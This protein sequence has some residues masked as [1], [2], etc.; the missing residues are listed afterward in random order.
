MF[1]N[2]IKVAF[3]NILKQRVFSFINIFGLAVA[4]SICMGI[5]MLVADQMMVDR[6]NPLSN[7]IYRINSIPYFKD[8][9][10]QIPGN[11]T[12]T[13]TLPLRDELLNNYTGVE[14]AVRLMRG[15]GNGWLELEPNHDINVPV[16]GYFADP[17]VL[18][19]FNHE[20]Q[21]GDPKTALVE[22]YSVVLTKK[23]A[24]KL[25]KVENPVGES[26]KVGKLGTYKV[27]G[28]IKETEN[29]SHIVVDAFASMSTVKS[30]A[31]AN[32]LG[33]EAESWHAYT[34]GWVYILLEEGK[35]I[36]DIQSSL[37]KISIDHFSELTPPHTTV[38]KYAFQNLLEIVPGRMIN[39]PIGPFMPW[40]II[41]F[42]AGI[43]GI[44]LVTSCF[45]FTN[46]S[47]ARS[48]S[49][50]KEIGVRKVTGAS[51]WQL[52]T[53]FLSESVIIS[54]FALV[55]GIVMIY[56][57][58]PFIVD[59]AFAR[60]LKW[61]LSA[62]YLVYGVFFVFAVFVGLL[63]GLF[64][65]GVLSGFQPIK[66]L[67]DMANTRLMSK[68]GLR[69]A[70]LVVQFSLSM[71]FILTVIVIY[72]QLNLFLHN[73]N[74]FSTSNKLIVHRGNTSVVS[75]K[76][77]LEKQSNIVSVSAASHIPLAGISYGD[78]FK[79]SLDE[80]EWRNASYFS[81]DENYLENMNLTLVAGKFFSAE[82]GASNSNFIILNE[83]AV[84]QHQFGS[85]ADAIGQVLI[86]ERDSAEMQILGVVKDYHFEFLDD[87]LGPLALIYNPEEFSLLQVVYAG[88][89]KSAT[90]TVENVWAGINPGLKVEVRD[91]EAEMGTLYEIVFGTLVKVLGF[92]AFLAIVIS[93][94][95]LLGMA[96]YTIQTRKKEIAIRKILGSSNR[97]LVYHLSK[98]F[99]AILLM[100]LAISVPAAYFLNTSWLQELANHVSVD[101]ST[102][103][104]GVL[105]LTFFGLFTIGSQTLQA[106]FVNPAENL[107]NE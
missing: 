41:Y 97:S 76:T 22:P 59:L 55:V 98:G 78:G 44:V 75:F 39:N 64:P 54:L 31:A 80:K 34:N 48:L 5:I 49:R 101:F 23:A 35:S 88:N 16:A 74:G 32:V 96:T 90:K 58:R 14:K 36:H 91:F 85:P 37:S 102:I 24:E 33:G 107:K 63:A 46:L 93:C 52:F 69:K 27:T 12:A 20:L 50:A 62:N 57:L 72:N 99:I 18:E 106:L 15:F 26:L 92:I 53:Q 66:V 42:L 82:A 94:L 83:A 28:V 30:L 79:K 67:K 1:K 45:N 81:V 77:E 68:V 9:K 10:A 100:A 86:M 105:V 38:V 17:E 29:R 60:F 25:F 8:G 56:A 21:Y 65:A 51:R 19:M 104:L 71:I 2:Y 89:F 47:I 3:R 87:D 13:T 61:N 73:D 40:V 95:G 7:R 84:K 6:H 43:A 70:L 4:M 11:E 103:M